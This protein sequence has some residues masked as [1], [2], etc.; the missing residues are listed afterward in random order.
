MRWHDTR[1]KVVIALAAT[2]MLTGCA[3][4][5]KPK[6][7]AERHIDAPRPAPAGNALD[8][9][10][11]RLHDLCGLLLQYY[12]VNKRLP[13]S[14]VELATLQD[15]DRFPIVC[16]IS[17]KPY[18]YDPEGYQVP[19]MPGRVIIVD[20]EPAHG[21]YRWAIAIESGSGPPVASVVAIP[22]IAFQR[23][24]I[25]PQPAGVP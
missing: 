11:N 8:P 13:Q 16:P 22:E 5:D 9:C 15:T 12:L 3:A 14:L 10:A 4:T 21:S 6:A 23:T 2:A 1:V 25:H 24:P 20:P 18:L 17:G 19:Q 7:K